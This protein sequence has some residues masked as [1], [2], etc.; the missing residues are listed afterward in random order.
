MVRVESPTAELGTPRVLTAAW[1][2]PVAAPPLPS[3]GVRIADGRITAV[4]PAAGIIR[5]G[6]RVDD[7][8][9]AL[10]TPGLVNPHTHLE[11]TDYAGRIPPGSL[12]E[13]L[14]RLV[15]LR[16]APGQAERETAAVARGAAQSLAAGVTCVGDISRL[17]LHWRVLRRRPIRKVCYVE[18]LALADDPPRNVDELRAAAD[19]VV[20]DDRL[21]VGFTPHAPYSV[22]ADQL[23][24]AL[25]LAHERGRP[26]C[27]HWAETRAERAFLLGETAALPPF[28]RDLLAQCGLRSPGLSAIELL[29][30]C[31][32]DV[33]PGLLAHFNYAEAG[34]AER[35]A[36]A[37]HTVVYCPR[38]HQYFGH[39]P[40]PFRAMQRAGVRVALGTDSAASN[41]DLRLLAEAQFVLTQTPDP[42]PPAALLRMITLDAAHALELGATIGSLEPGKWADL[43]AFPCDPASPDPVADL[44]RTAPAPL[45]VWVAGTRVI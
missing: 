42:P 16:R 9:A 2:A 22:P 44:V 24:A 27:T 30:R 32:A 26:W 7:L 12:W 4:G 43:A 19:E 23:R 29:E 6:D 8:G 35:L 28:L 15:V 37:G 40:H 20:E 14:P 36:A 25:R 10:L 45:G 38:A 17:N 13:W 18:L 33:R 11:L 21:T 39:P 31:A 34:E 1:V 3:G 5:P 41:H